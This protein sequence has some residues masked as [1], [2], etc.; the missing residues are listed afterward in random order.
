MSNKTDD[1]LDLSKTEEE[2]TDSGVRLISGLNLSDM[3]A[4]KGG[5]LINPDY[6]GAMPVDN[7]TSYKAKDL[8]RVGLKIESLKNLN[9]LGDYADIK[10]K[11]DSITEDGG[12]HMI[13]LRPSYD[14]EAEKPPYRASVTIQYELRIEGQDEPFD[15][16]FIRAMPER[17][18]LHSNQLLPGLEILIENIRVGETVLA[19]L[20]SKYAFGE[21]GVP[22]RSIPENCEILAV[23]KLLAFTPQGEAEMLLDLDM[24]ERMKLSVFDMLTAVHKEHQVANH[25]AKTEEWALAKN[26][27]NFCVTIL[28]ERQD[29]LK[30]END[31]IKTLLE[32]L[33][34][35][36]AHCF[37]KLE[38]CNKAVAQCKKAL[39]LNENSLKGHYRL[40]KAY[41]M[42]E[43]YTKAQEHLTLA[44][45]LA[46]R[47]PIIEQFDMKEI[48]KL[49]QLL[50]HNKIAEKAFAKNVFK[51]VKKLDKV[52]G[53]ADYK[54]LESEVF[55]TLEEFARD[56]EIKELILPAIYF[57][58]EWKVLKQCVDHLHLNI[59]IISGIGAGTSS[60][61]LLIT[62]KS[63]K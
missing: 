7:E 5:A 30:D 60:Q 46:P 25:F 63:T 42:L 52:K 50:C 29:T 58:Q 57:N 43:M 36:K 59:R 39:G 9:I 2:C 51:H 34:L 41:T 3:N 24:V 48:V 26:H 1:L 33:Y 22:Q 55:K 13:C 19:I 31:E 35:N 53:P 18:K 8:D 23:V 11:M 21:L 40:G 62:K 45:N 4:R 14:K 6:D 17:F 61:K 28:E 27:Y 56:D 54:F 47:D 44:H 10:T 16:T 20:S 37:I 38:Q 12:V 15:S 32:K 49:D